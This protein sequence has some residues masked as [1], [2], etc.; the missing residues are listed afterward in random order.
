MWMANKLPFLLQDTLLRMENILLKRG[1]KIKEMLS[2]Q[3][4]LIPPDIQRPV[5]QKVCESR[6]GLTL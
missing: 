2:L 1:T 6:L 3:T 5:I 4:K